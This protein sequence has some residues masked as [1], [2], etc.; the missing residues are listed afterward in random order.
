MEIKPIYNTGT[1][2]FVE[3]PSKINA[4]KINSVY[5]QDPKGVIPNGIYKVFKHENSRFLFV[6]LLCS[7][8]LISQGILMSLIDSVLKWGW[9]WYIPA[10]IIAIGA[11]GKLIYTFVEYRGLKNSINVYRDDLNSGLKTTPPFISDIYIK[12]YKKQVSHN[13][14]T[15][16]IIFYGIIIVSIFWWLKDVNWWIFD[17]KKWIGDL[18]PAPENLAIYMIIG[19]IG[20][21]TVYIWFTIFRKK[22]ILDIQSFFGNEVISQVEIHKMTDTMNKAYK[23]IFFLSILV[24]LVIPIIVKLVMNKFNGKK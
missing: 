24:I 21:M 2:T 1:I 16:A 10:T 18:G 9:F 11:L 20:V 14:I 8:L 7:L 23:R 4:I 15:I 5:K 22:R 17:F 12:L 13:W 6:L 19:L 3:N